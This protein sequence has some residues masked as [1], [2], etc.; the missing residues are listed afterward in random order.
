MGGRRGG[1]R[2]GCRRTR[3][4]RW[5][6]PRTGLSGWGPRWGWSGSTATGFQ[7]FDKNS[8]SAG[9]AGERRA[10]FAGDQGRG[11]VDRDQRGAGAVEGRERYCVHDKRRAAG[12]RNSWVGRSRMMAL[13]W[14]YTDAGL[15]RQSEGQFQ[16]KE[17]LGHGVEDYSF[18][19]GRPEQRLVGPGLDG[20]N[21]L[22]PACPGRGSSR[23]GL[24]I[25]R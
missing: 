6:R 12:E 11:A 13:V 18:F 3:C 22:E 5:C 2:T 16:G 20:Q 17:L 19:E 25:P 7:V 4:R 23:G 1:W 10:V 8:S 9:A 21:R 15:A 14:A 24:R